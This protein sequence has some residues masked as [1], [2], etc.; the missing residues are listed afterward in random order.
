[1][2]L[3]SIAPFDR[4]RE[5]EL[6]LLSRVLLA[7]SFAP[8]AEIHHGAGPLTHLLL[9]IGGVSDSAGNSIGPIVGLGSFLADAP[10]PRLIAD[11]HLG[12]EILFINR[13][14]FFTLVREC[15]ELLRGFLE[16][17]PAGRRLS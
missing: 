7:R 3:R 6:A 4:V 15:P 2:A 11:H 1:L 8:G 12:A 9:V 10:T 13:P 5:S 16:V 17:G 14:T